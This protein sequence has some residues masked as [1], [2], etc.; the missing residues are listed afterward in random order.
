MSQDRN[1]NQ[2]HRHHQN[3]SFPLE[4]RMEDLLL[5]LLLLLVDYMLVL[6]ALAVD[7][8]MDQA[9]DRQLVG[10]GQVEEHT[11]VLRRHHLHHLQLQQ[12]CCLR[13]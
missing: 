12:C 4:L 6:A 10:V 9:L 11:P 2:F 8:E 13:R 5:R 7:Q 1:R 3:P